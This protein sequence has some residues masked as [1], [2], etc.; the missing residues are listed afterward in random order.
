MFK[1][2]NPN[3]FQVDF[4]LNDVFK[5]PDMLHRVEQ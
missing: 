1:L 3:D 4:F 5:I 2:Y